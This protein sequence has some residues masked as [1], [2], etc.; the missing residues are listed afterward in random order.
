VYNN[1]EI[2]SDQ[3][4]QTFVYE[5]V[6]GQETNTK[7]WFQG[8]FTRTITTEI[9]LGDTLIWSQAITY[10]YRPTYPVIAKADYSEDPCDGQP[11]E[12][13]YAE[14]FKKTRVLGY[15]EHASGAY[16]VDK[17]ETWERGLKPWKITSENLSNFS[18]L[19]NTQDQPAAIDDYAIYGHED[20]LGGEDII[21]YSLETYTHTAQI[22][23]EVCPKDYIHLE[24]TR[25]LDQ[26]QL[27]SDFTFRLFATEI[28]YYQVS[29]DSP[30]GQVAYVGSGQVWTKTETRGSYDTEA[31]TFITQPSREFNA[32]PPAAKWIRPRVNQITAFATINNPLVSQNGRLYQDRPE[33]LAADFCYTE[34]QLQTF[35]ARA[36]SEN[37]GLAQ[38]KEIAVPYFRTYELGDSIQYT[39]QNGVTGQYLVY[40]ISLIQD[41]PTSV[42]AITLAQSP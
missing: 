20:I 24:T 16:L 33:P 4:Q 27:D 34:E 26:Y 36:L 23:P 29:G 30:T 41:G 5:T 10:G 6:S 9:T 1:Y 12:T 35:G 22:S 17:T 21:S 42:K 8:G 14:I 18:G 7:P 19:D 28:D 32:N 2:I 3:Q 40:S 11:I 39:D 37:N 13:E 38:A 31:L 25:R 15:Q